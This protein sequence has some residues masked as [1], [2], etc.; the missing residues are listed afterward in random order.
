VEEK[1]R[2]L[3]LMVIIANTFL[4]TGLLFSQ[5]GGDYKPEK[6][7]L[8]AEKFDLSN[9]RLF[10]GTPFYRAQELNKKILLSYDPDRLMAR[11]RSEAGMKPKAEAYGGW[12]AEG[13]AG[14]SLGHYLSGCSLMFA[15]T[16]DSR[17]KNRVDYLVDEL[18]LCQRANG[19][20]YA[21]CIPRGK[22]LF[23]E[24]SEGKIETQRFNLNGCWVPIY[25]LHKEMAGLRDAFHLCGNKK[26]LEVERRLADWF[27]TIIGHLNDDQMQKIMYCEHGGI[28]EVLLDLYQDT[29]DPR[30]LELA[31]K[32]WHKEIMDPMLQGKDILPG[33]HG[34]T[35]IP[36]FIGLARFYEMTGDRRAKIASEFFWDR[37]V[38]HHSYVTGGHGLNEYFGPPDTLSERLDTDTTETCN[39]YNMLKQTGH[40]F[41]WKPEARYFDYYER[42]LL[43]HI[44]ASEHP[45]NGTVVYNLNLEMGGFKHFQNPE[46]FTCCIGTGMENHSKYG[47]SIYFHNDEELYVNLFIA[48]ELNWKEKG[49]T[50]RQETAFP[51]DDAISLKFHSEKPV[52]LA[53]CIRYPYWAEKGAEVRINGLTVE[54]TSIPSSYIKLLRKWED[55][56]EIT[57]RFPF[58]LRLES[59][60]DNPGRT[61][62]FFGPVLLAGILGAVDDSRAVDPMFVPV[63][64][65]SGKP[66]SEWLRPAEGKTNTFWLSGVG[67]P[68][69]VELRPFYRTY[70]CRYT[71]YWDLVD[72]AR[73]KE[74]QKQYEQ[75]QKEKL[76]LEKRTIDFVQ[77]GQQKSEVEH[78]I[79]LENS[80]EGESKGK[81]WRSARDGGWFSYELKLAQRKDLLLR[82]TYGYV[83]RNTVVEFYLDNEKF[84]E[85]VIQGSNSARMETVDYPL[86]YELIKGKKAITLKIQSRPGQMIPAIFEVRI[87]RAKN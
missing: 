42:A 73:W 55:G 68:A 8:K 24:V 59:M 37:V 56:D 3:K 2:L 38:N 65:T 33:Y 77:P 36:K 43:N 58:S 54:V 62:I 35:Q 83:R 20:G 52:R 86:P 9:I 12:E 7:Q 23:K 76:E 75:L 46:W 47:E 80:E 45:E 48:S 87:I 51:E 70:D 19:N 30:Y 72:E 49:L 81:K 69:D 50:I 71:V 14:H 26:A 53:V 61:A 78:K 40:L 60:P 27:Y 41:S 32:F 22:E 39:V 15:S 16:G 17:F 66:V 21:M 44:L 57:F 79:K 67:R 6:I 18:E 74:K 10:E 29:D 4:L 28:M 84:K 13:I 5:S 82:V 31:R 85:Q 63:L 64:L 1:M 34:N 25:T 11:F